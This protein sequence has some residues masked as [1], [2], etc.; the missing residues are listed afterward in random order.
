[1]TLRVVFDTNIVISAALDTQ[2]HLVPEGRP[3]LCLRLAFAGGVNLVL[4]DYLL[5]EY[6]EVLLRA[7][8]GFSPRWVRE[9]LD[10]IRSNGILVTPAIIPARVRVD[11]G[12]VEVLGTAAAGSAAFLVTGNLRH[13]PTRYRSTKI[14]SPNAF[15]SAVALAS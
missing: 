1:M 8:F 14:V 15:L 3:S 7:R 12:D 9:L 4:S 2:K 13:F 11:P 5:S 10:L 6:E